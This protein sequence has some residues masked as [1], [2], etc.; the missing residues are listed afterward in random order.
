[1]CSLGFFLFYILSSC[2]VELPAAGWIPSSTELLSMA[3]AGEEALDG[4]SGTSYL[5]TGLS[6]A[7]KFIS[8]YEMCFVVCI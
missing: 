2:L 1:M 6:S 5:R 3:V 8:H 4:C 7:L